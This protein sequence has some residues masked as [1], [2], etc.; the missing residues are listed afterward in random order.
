VDVR[1]LLASSFPPDRDGIAS[2]AVQLAASLRRAGNQV[3]VVSPQPSAAHFHTDFHTTPGL[4]RLL[5]LSRR[6]DRTVVEFVA[7]HFFKSLRPYDFLLHWPAFAALLAFGRRVEL[8]VHEAPYKDLAHASPP[9]GWVVRTLWRA[10][11]TLPSAT[12]VHTHWE[13][14]QLVRSVNIPPERI[15]VL[16]HGRDF[17]KRTQLDRAEARRELGLRSDQYVFLCIGFLQ[18]HKGFD[19][20]VRALHRLNGNDLRLEIAGSMRVPAPE[21]AEYVH[22][23]RTL[24]DS[25]PR[26]TLHEGYLDDDLFDRWIVACDTVILPYRDIWSSGVVER[27]KLYGRSLIV[28]NV[29]GLPEQA[30]PLARV[31]RNDEDLCRA[32]ADAAHVTMS[33]AEPALEPQLANGSSTHMAPVSEVIRSRAAALRQRSE[34]G[35]SARPPAHVDTVRAVPPLR[36]ASAESERGPRGFIK[37][38]VARLTRW[39]L[40]PIV[41]RVNDLEY[42]GDARLAKVQRELSDLRSALSRLEGV[43]SHTPNGHTPPVTSGSSEPKAVTEIEKG[44]ADSAKAD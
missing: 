13:R 22:E 40:R 10:M 20:A 31:V 38:I 34:H 39:E 12:Y 29:G 17:L 6:A 2:Y 16:D 28:S 37:E 35:R 32:M 42:K 4:L 5:Y 25:T 30:G 43:N 19:R 7:S 26:A 15:Q 3:D 21:I 18:A 14:E 8:V 44:V 11:L 9:R 41:N 23:L 33:A 1:I 27:A 36:L 24:V